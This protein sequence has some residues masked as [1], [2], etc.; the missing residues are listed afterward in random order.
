MSNEPWERRVE[1]GDCVL[2][3][4]DCREIIPHLEGIDATVTDPPY[5]I[6]WKPRI[7]NRDTPW[8]DKIDFSI[9]DILTGKYHLLW[10]G[11]YFANELPV[12]EGWL[13][14]CKRP[15]AN[16]HNDARSYSSTE[17]AWRNWGKSRFMTHVW[18]GGMRAGDAENRLFLHPAQKPIEIMQWCLSLLPDDVAVVFDP[19]MG[20]GTTGVAAV[21]MGRKFIGIE[22]EPIYF[23]IACKR[24]EDAAKQPDMLVVA[25][26][27]PKPV[28]G[29]MF[30]D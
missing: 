18:D 14:W 17:L 23:D 20:S 21:K 9:N 7:N 22:R 1:I 24:I 30:A 2:Y 25:E 28:N 3:Q 4:G 11:Q 8:V 29:D 6:G 5:G 10:G 27:E 16:F 13:T 12:A 26:P 19:F 15:Q